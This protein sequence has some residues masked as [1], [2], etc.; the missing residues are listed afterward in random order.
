M[1]RIYPEVLRSLLD[2]LYICVTHTSSFLL[3]LSFVAP[4]FFFYSFSLLFLFSFFKH[5]LFCLIISHIA[6]IS[7]YRT[8]NVLQN[9]LRT[10][11]LKTFSDLWD[12]VCCMKTLL[13][14]LL[15]WTL[16]F[17]FHSL[18]F[19]NTLIFVLASFFHSSFHNSCH[20][21]FQCPFFSL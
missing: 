18:Y 10:N 15:Y 16:L 20:L 1:S 19:L 13:L 12:K 11:V 5:F 9:I 2:T 21:F 3:T 8:R 6:Q 17:I 7:F 4:L 14:L